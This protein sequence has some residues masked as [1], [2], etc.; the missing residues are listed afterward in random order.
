[1]NTTTQEETDIILVK[2][3]KKEKDPQPLTKTLKAVH[4][5]EKIPQTT[6]TLKPLTYSQ[7]NWHY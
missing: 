1:M 2:A 3:Q 4:T 6:P 5:Q 7:P